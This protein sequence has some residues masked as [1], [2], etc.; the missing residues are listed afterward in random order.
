MIDLLKNIR[1][2]VSMK[3]ENTSETKYRKAVIK[4][5]IALLGK[6]IS[7]LHIRRC[8]FERMG[9]GN[10][11]NIRAI[12]AGIATRRG[13]REQLERCLYRINFREP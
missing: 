4:A 7:I 1:K 13:R 5:Q 8:G 3:I 2:E 11:N 10:E 12:D 9:Q 6:G